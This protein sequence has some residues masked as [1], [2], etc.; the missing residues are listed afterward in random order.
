MPQFTYTAIDTEGT[1]ASGTVNARNR[2][3]ALDEVAGRGLTPVTLAEGGGT[4]AH[5][6]AR[7]AGRVS[8]A[9]VES[10]SRELASLLAA[11]VPMN[12]ALGILR[13]QASNQAAKRQWSAIHD[14][15]SGGTALADAMSR[16]PR[17]FPA[18]YTAM[19][20]AGETGGFLDVVL[21]QIADFR[22]REH[23]L[24]SKV[25]SALVYPVI[26]AVLAVA[27]LIFLMVYFIPRFSKLFDDFGAA[28]PDL[29][30]A[31]IAVSEGMTAYG[32]FAVVGVV[33]L[34]LLA[35]RILAADAGRLA[36]ER[37]LLRVPGLGPVLARF[38]LVRFCR[39][40]GTLLGSGVPL[41]ASLKVAKESLGN[42]TL[43]AAMDLSIEQVRQGT[44]LAR[45]LASCRQLFPGAV[46]EMI[47][48]SEESGRLDVELKRLAGV[49]EEELD[50]RL[51]LLVALVEPALLF[52]MAAIVGTIV[53]GMLLPIFTLQE[54]IR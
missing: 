6:A 1:K 36:W 3:A 38:A 2:A 47:A 53:V 26:L 15:V 13:D 29:T 52:L 21:M 48:V 50:R 34:A 25:W 54:H 11:G 45:S 31:I 22:A 18:V 27:V 49:Y 35:R 5:A 30:R 28:L 42:Q 4:E 9:A 7:P 12:R 33:I 40:L 20:R 10:F 32:L 46:I 19:V 41:V 44:S 51:R 17:S 23:G 39:M 8:A 43:A 16:F 14:D 24:K 37:F